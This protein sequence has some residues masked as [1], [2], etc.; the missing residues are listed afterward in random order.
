MGKKIIIGSRGS[1][2]ALLYAQQ[3]KDKIIQNT[4]LE[5][6]DIIIKEIRTKGD[7]VQ[8]MRL[9]ELGGKGLFSSN[10]EK[11]LIDKDIDIAVHAFK[12]MP[13]FETAG[14][15]TEVF[16]KRNDPREVL[17]TTDKKKLKEINFQ[18]VIGTSSYRREFQIK[19]IRPDVI[20]KLIRGNVETRIKK[21]K[22]GMYDAIILSY[23]GVKYLSLENEISEIF[24]TE[25]IIPSAG[26]GIIALQC[27]EDDDK[28]FSVLKKINHYETYIRAHT[29]KNILKVLEGDCET[30]VGA[31]S[32]VEG[33]EI[34]L[35][36]E[37]FSLDG[38]ERF[39]QKKSSKISKFKELGNE[40]GNILKDKSNKSYKR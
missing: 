24:T 7:E 17:I 34:F 38:S 39:Y 22:D 21:L 15:R 27:R 26:Q 3:A 9:S 23:V 4:N 14:L 18:S 11:K 29:E 12:D 13:A 36:A 37:L 30:A 35:E 20:C 31:F 40:V 1:N 19:K 33:D 32:K 25:E 2:L 8:D 16:L 28:I 5:D 6:E 10:I